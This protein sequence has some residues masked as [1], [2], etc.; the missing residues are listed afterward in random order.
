MVDELFEQDRGTEVVHT[1]VLGELAHA[2]RDADACGEMKDDI[3]ILECEL[4]DAWIAHVADHE[5]DATIEIR[6][7]AAR[8]V[9]LRDECIE[10]A[11]AVATREQLVCEMRPDEAGSSGDQNPS[12]PHESPAVHGSIH[13]GWIKIRSRASTS[14]SRRA[15]DHR[16]QR[17][18]S[19]MIARSSLRDPARSHT[20][21]ERCEHMLRV[22]ESIV[23]ENGDRNLSH[24]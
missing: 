19:M 7:S 16:K 11:D 1:R 3:Y 24:A 18:R 20:R 6:W 9:Y 2:L 17:G 23:D 15:D 14:S 13:G 4:D 5:I 10:R 22:A 8:A 12:L 21:G